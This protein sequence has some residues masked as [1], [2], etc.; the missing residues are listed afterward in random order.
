MN[1]EEYYQQFTQEH[2]D[3]WEKAVDE[4]PDAKWNYNNVADLL[5]FMKIVLPRIGKNQSLFGLSLISLEGDIE[6][7]KEI[8]RHGLEPLQTAGV[9]DDEDVETL[10][11][12]FTKSTPRWDSHDR[13]PQPS[14]FE[15][16]IE[17]GGAVYTLRTDNYRRYRDLNLIR[18]REV[19]G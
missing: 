8:V 19:N 11:R 14:N 2:I 9:L 12:W 3:I 15:K 16:T 1:V 10:V 7:L 18:N 6:G 5:P 4:R 17:V 13:T